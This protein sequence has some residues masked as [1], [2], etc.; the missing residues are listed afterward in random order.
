LQIVYSVYSWLIIIVVFLI[1]VS[2]VF[3]V[4]QNNPV[5][6]V[7]SF[8]STALLLFVFLILIGA[9]FFALLIL[10]IYTGV[11]TVLFLFVVIMYNFRI[12][13]FSH[14]FILFNP[15]SYLVL[16]KAMWFSW[17]CNKALEPLLKQQI[18]LN[19]SFFTLDVVQFIALFNDHYFLFLMCGLLIF[20]AMIGS[21]VITYPFYK[22]N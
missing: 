17:C 4:L 20:I 2:L 5:Y 10:I 14:Y 13:E 18:Q 15:F 21:I 16:F 3:L 22:H 8:I 19:T 12:V 9:E 6:A 7:F 11:I 1:L